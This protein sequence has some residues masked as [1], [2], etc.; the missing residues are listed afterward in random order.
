MN[1]IKKY[2]LIIL[3]STTVLYSQDL[4]IDTVKAPLIIENISYIGLKYANTR[5][6]SEIPIKKGDL[7]DDIKKKAVTEYLKKL[8]SENIF[9]KDGSKIEEILL[10]SGAVEIVISVSESLP[11][12]MFA[13]P[14]YSTT[15]GF[16]A[17]IKYWQFFANGFKAPLEGQLEYLA[18][19]NFN[20]FIR[21][22]EP[23]NINDAVKFSFDVDTYTTIVNYMS[24]LPDWNNRLWE[25]GVKN[26]SLNFDFLAP[27]VNMRINPIFSF[28]YGNLLSTEP[29]GDILRLK[30]QDHITLL[31]PNVYLYL[32]I[33]DDESYISSHL[34]FGFKN[35]FSQSYK[36]INFN[37]NEFSVSLFG[38]NPKE[39]KDPLSNPV[40]ITAGFFNFPSIDSSLYTDVNFAFKSTVNQNSDGALYDNLLLKEFGF[41]VFEDDILDKIETDSE[42]KFLKSMYYKNYDDGKYILTDSASGAD[43]EKIW[44]ILTGINFV[45]SAG[46]DLN[47]NV[48]FTFNIPTTELYF[49]PGFIFYY[50]SKW[51]PTSLGKINSTANN[52]TLGG[53]LGVKY[54]IPYIDVP[55]SLNIDLR[56]SRDWAAN[57]LTENY[58]YNV[59]NK[60]IIYDLSAWFEKDFKFSD[61]YL[62][63]QKVSDDLIVNAGHKLKI[64][65]TLKGDP[66]YEDGYKSGVSYSSN[67]LQTSFELL[68]Q[69]YLPVYKDHRF[70][71]RA[72]I[73]STYNHSVDSS[74]GSTFIGNWIRGKGFSA[75]SGYFGLI[76]NL[77]YWIPLF[78][79][80]TPGILGK[81]LKKDLI[82][83][84]YWVLYTDIAIS[85]T[86]TETPYTLDKNMAHILPALTIGTAFRVYPKFVPLIINVEVNVNAYN[87]IKDK[88]SFTS[89][90]YFEFSIAREVDTSWFML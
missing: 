58:N 65:F 44:D 49:T 40:K 21:T 13:L 64:N 59:I 48:R 18:K 52:I 8:E 36:Q 69:L 19:D 7:W 12:F 26:I 43:K 62:K 47:P 88:G 70:K 4:S 66:V 24:T 75:Y 41:S 25:N 61:H 56:Y 76:I 22:N 29:A 28:G 17:K 23:I 68:Y 53:T 37:K 1:F 30:D 10:P 84:V 81:K 6:T 33:G 83:Q 20:L 34:G 27:V 72:L 89:Y 42:K 50:N 87:M 15:K 51:E 57:Y 67:N 45:Y 73:Y 2:F 86:E 39:I 11:F 9:E 74:F 77:D 5:V 16:K 79:I 35:L 85:L 63:S 78:T 71:A 55:I 60:F 82:W 14:F 3:L 90:I 31:N 80:N 38:N 54:T 32:P 46:L